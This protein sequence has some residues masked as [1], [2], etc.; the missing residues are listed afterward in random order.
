[1]YAPHTVT[2]YNVAQNPLTDTPVYNVTILE[3]VFLDVAE[4]TNIQKSGLAD[5]DAA[6]LFVPFSV[7]ATDG[8]DH[9]AK[10]YL[11]PKRYNA[12]TLANRA[13]YWTLETGGQDTG[14]QC[15]FVKGVQVSSDGYKAMRNSL[16]YVYDIRTVDIRDFGSEDMQHW[17]VGGK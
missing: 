12:L 13:P 3:G 1:M 15:F 6:T 11:A 7:K 9:T 10:T 17:Q 16:D 4:A 8:V 2:L 5:A 14:T